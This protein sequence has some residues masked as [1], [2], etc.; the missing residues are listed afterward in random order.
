MIKE[1]NQEHIDT[2]IK[3]MG[4]RLGQVEIAPI[5]DLNKGQGF[6]WAIE[7]KDKTIAVGGVR[8]L[9]PGTGEAWMITTSEIEKSPV[10][11]SKALRGALNRADENGFIRVQC[12][13]NIHFLESQKWVE[14]AGFSME[15]MLESYINKENY[16]M[17]ARVRNG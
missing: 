6:C 16:F 13:V 1:A 7:K 11:V 5:T 9:W 17:Y 10:E 8:E 2:M 15:A 14:S 3:A 12:V 4:S